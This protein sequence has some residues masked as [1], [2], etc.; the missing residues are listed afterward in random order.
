MAQK[1]QL[2]SS[3]LD[4]IRFQLRWHHQFQF[5]GYYA[6]KEKGFYERAGFDVTLVAGS[7][8]VE[9]VT[10]VLAGRAHY[11]EG[12]SEVLY[13]RLKGE[14]L[15]AM[16]VIFQHSPSVLLALKSSGIATPQD[17]VGK[18]V[19]S[20]G[21][22]GD[23]VFLAMMNKQKVPVEQVEIIG[24]SYQIDDLV[25]GKTDA[26]NSYLTNEPFYLEQQGVPYNIIAPKDYGVDFYSDILFTTEEEANNNPERVRRFKEATLQGW[27]Y[28]FANP[29]EII[30]II[31]EKYN[32]T[33]TL[34]H[35]RFE[36]LS[37]QG[38]IMP[39]L[40]EIGYINQE[41]FEAMAQ[42]FL[43][44]GM[45]DNLDA[46]EG[47]IFDEEEGVSDEVYSLLIAACL[48]LVAALLVAMVLALF[49]HRLQNE[50][51]ERK[52]VE[53]KLMQL[54]D[55]DDLTQLLNRRAFTKRYNDELV[56]AQRYGDIFSV[57]LLDLDLFK[58]VNDRYGHEAGDRVL[59]AVADLLREDTRESDICGRFGGEEFILLLPK[60]PLA[61]A[62][63]YAERLCQHFRQYPIGLRDDKSVTITASI[64]VVEW[65]KD[66]VD[67]ATILKADK[68]L[69]K[70]KSE[71]RDQV[72]IYNDSL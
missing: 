21:G 20:V 7:P 27:K 63:V 66:D 69:Y 28:A 38:L 70:A 65:S 57:L 54:A 71:G 8:E 12:N 34:N 58:K 39:D 10:E 25:Q 51:Q 15:V 2:I 5:A 18:R 45:I 50:I 32:D 52:T 60:T 68:A 55:T 36:A 22:Q 16:A 40:V 9:P 33:K 1:D 61:E 31:R 67:E 47:F 56:R 17:L 4:P 19:M 23:A 44:Q 72:A 49:N 6:A 11:A 13:S 24:S 64:G 43:Q 37:I 53:T 26:F 46:L 30:Q 62:V 42:V 48:F 41:R 3:K 59:K 14:P 35:M 29:E